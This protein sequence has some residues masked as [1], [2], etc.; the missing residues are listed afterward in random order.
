VFLNYL[1]DCLPA[2]VL[3]VEGETVRQLCVRTCLARGVNLADHTDL[4][5]D[6]LARRA[7]STREEDR[8]E[9]LELYGFL[10]AEYDYRPA[11]VAQLPYADFALGLARTQ[12]RRLLHS[13]GAIRCLERLLG[14]LHPQGFILAN[15][16]GQTHVEHDAEYEHQR[17]SQATFIGVNF[18]QLKAYL[19]RRRRPV[20]V[21]GAA[22]R[23]R[24][25][26]HAAAGPRPG[27]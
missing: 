10:A 26:A 6:D 8:R 16:Y 12:T 13:Y 22:G 11:D 4:S 15:D 5:A 23:Q 24:Q 25:P 9:L 27:L 14:L 21:A 18:P 19:L 3:E 20:Q 2:A 7:A 17:F 1:L